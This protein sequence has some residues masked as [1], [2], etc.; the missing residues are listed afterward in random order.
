MT[1]CEFVLLAEMPVTRLV[2]RPLVLTIAVGIKVDNTGRGASSGWFDEKRGGRHRGVALK[3]EPN[4]PVCARR[5]GDRFNSHTGSKRVDG[6]ILR[7]SEHH[8]PCGCKE[9]ENKQATKELPTKHSEAS[10]RCELH[11]VKL[12]SP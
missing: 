3:R 2:E 8:G 1:G 6:A 11:P 4:R 10:V 7:L 5:D 9:Q 12:V